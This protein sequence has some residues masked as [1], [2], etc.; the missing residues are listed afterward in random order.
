MSL[1]A[2]DTLPSYRNPPITEVV[3]GVAF[4][5][6]SDLSV[7]HL[8]DLWRTRW[9]DRFP[10]VEEHPPYSPPIERFDMP[11]PGPGI[12]LEF[13]A[14]PTTRLWFVTGDGQ[15]LIQVQRDWLACNWRKVRPGD[16]YDRW[17]ARRAAFERTFGEFQGY[18]EEQG[19]GKASVVQCEVTY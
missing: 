8:G 1:P 17:P 11:A 13:S 19:L 15:E 7:A 16:T 14:R 10:R 6:T 2:S 9:E 5:D 12:S 18:L 3:V 4:K